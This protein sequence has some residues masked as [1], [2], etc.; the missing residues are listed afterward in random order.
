MMRAFFCLPSDEQL[1]RELS[2]ISA[3][4]RARM[5][6]RVSWVA[7]GNFHVTVRFLGEIDPMLTVDLERMVRPIAAEVPPFDLVVDRLGAFPSPQKARV[8]W[9]GGKA[10]SEFTELV[11]KVNQGLDRFGFPPDRKE[12]LA[13]ITLGRVKGKPDPALARILSELEGAVN[14]TLRVDRVVLMEST[15]TPRGAVYSPLFTLRL[16]GGRDVPV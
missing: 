4:L 7:E 6:A 14:F 1:N 3:D 12:A 10:P 13:H 8:I 9:A 5:T 15:L 16:E 11:S 2:A